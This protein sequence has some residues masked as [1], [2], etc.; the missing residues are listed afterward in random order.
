L[1]RVGGGSQGD[2]TSE[3][4]ELTDVVAGLAV[5]VGAVAV[6]LYLGHGGQQFGRRGDE[7]VSA[8]RESGHDGMGTG[9]R[10]LGQNP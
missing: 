2:D 1:S 5:F 6:V 9:P 3:F 4:F 10:R 8:H 7:V